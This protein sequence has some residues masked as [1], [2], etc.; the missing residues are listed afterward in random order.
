MEI[1]FDDYLIRGWKESDALSLSRCANNR[2]IWL[3]LRDVFPNPYSLEDA[4]FWIKQSLEDDP[5]R[6][7]AIANSEE[8]IGGIGL[9]FQEDVHRY[10]AELGYWL[11]E[12]YWGLGIMTEAVKA[13]TEYAFNQFQLIRI[14]AGPFSR[15]HA[16]QRVLEKAG[17]S[18]EGML[19]NHVFKDGKILHQVLYGK[20]NFKIHDQMP[21][22]FGTAG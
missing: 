9:V 6:S 1:R 14:Y 11:A 8:I 5:E 18:R 3:N 13:L 17:F 20:Y 22:M 19:K 16:S 2:K 12:P 15:N 10:S 21:E 7:F 4:R